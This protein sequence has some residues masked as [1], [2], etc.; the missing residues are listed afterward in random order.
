MAED[1]EILTYEEPKKKR[2]KEL[3][4]RPTLTPREIKE[5]IDLLIERAYN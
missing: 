4:E 1:I 5:A 3:R 2:L